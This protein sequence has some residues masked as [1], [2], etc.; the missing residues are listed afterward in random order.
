MLELKMT[1]QDSYGRLNKLAASGKLRIACAH[2]GKLPSVESTDVISVSFPGDMS[3]TGVMLL[4]KVAERGLFTR[5]EDITLNG[6]HGFIGPA[7][8]ER[9]G[10]VDVLV[11]G[12]MISDNDASYTGINLFA[13]LLNDREIDVKCTS[14]EH[15]HFEAKTHLSIMGFARAT[16]YDMAMD[17]VI[18][19][20]MQDELFA[21]A[22]VFLNGGRGVLLGSGSYGTREKPSLSC[23]CDCFIMDKGLF[24]PPNDST[25]A[26]HTV[27]FL[28]PLWQDIDSKK[29][30][31]RI[32]E[33]YSGISPDETRILVECE[34]IMA[35][36]VEQGMLFVD[37]GPKPYRTIMSMR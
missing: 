34:H 13:D 10:V 37:P 33:L 7:P 8:N 27:T 6:L 1:E 9:L 24:L 4:V 28:F 17:T 19:E 22:T 21:G 35:K 12:G 2:D 36:A 5:A 31:Q 29:L 14:Q 11:T 25:P 30:F 3:G 23:A 18:A 26:R 15:Y 32:E 16:A 20:L